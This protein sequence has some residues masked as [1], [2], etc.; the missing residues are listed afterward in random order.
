MENKFHFTSFHFVEVD[1]IEM[2]IQ[3]IFR[4]NFDPERPFPL[5][6]KMEL[7]R[8]PEGRIQWLMK[9]IARV[10]TFSNM[11]MRLNIDLSH[12]I[13]NNV[14]TDMGTVNS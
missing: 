10:K 6:Y 13:Q 2:N 7:R 14:N 9:V 5:S 3:D 12:S 1:M 8:R 4:D 11:Y